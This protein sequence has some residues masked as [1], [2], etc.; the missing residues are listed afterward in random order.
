MEYRT[1]GEVTCGTTQPV[2]LSIDGDSLVTTQHTDVPILTGF[3]AF[4][5]AFQPTVDV[6]MTQ[7]D[8]VD[9]SRAVSILTGV[10]S[11]SNVRVRPELVAW[12]DA[13]A[14]TRATLFIDAEGE[15]V[16][17][18]PRY[19]AEASIDITVVT[20]DGSGGVP[21]EPTSEDMQFARQL[22]MNRELS[23]GGIQAVWDADAS[24]MI[25]VASSNQ[26]SRQLDGVIRWLGEDDSRWATLRG[27]V[28]A[29][30]LDRT[31]VDL[32]IAEPP[33]Q[34][35]NRA[36]VWIV[37]GVAVVVIATAVAAS[38]L[39]SRRSRKPTGNVPPDP[40]SSG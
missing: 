23:V 14:S 9:L 26:N 32:V 1:T 7:G 29:Q 13:V 35:T 28:V 8:V 19:V 33:D 36:A 27:D 4:P 22:T 16:Q 2:G 15:R 21:G 6:A 24:R 17:D 30:V 37:A 10:Q 25:L 18:L 11:L 5:Q 38:L 3:Q 39:V 34:P 31:P 12:E 40:A 20:R